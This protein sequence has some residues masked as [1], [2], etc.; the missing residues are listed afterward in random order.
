MKVFS[1]NNTDVASVADQIAA[2]LPAQPT[3]LLYF[4]S[5][6]FSPIDIAEVLKKLYPQVPTMGCSTAGEIMTGHM[7][8]GHL[9]IAGFSNEQVAEAKVK[10]IGQEGVKATYRELTGGAGDPDLATHVGIILMDGLASQEEVI[11]DALGSESDITF[12]GGSAGDE[13]K[14]VQTHV[15]A[16]SELV[17]HGG[18]L[19]LLHVPGGFDIIKTQ[20][21]SSTG[22]CLL[23]TKVDRA[24]RAVLEFDGKPA[25]LA[26]AEALGVPADSELLNSFMAHPLGLMAGD[27]PFVRAPLRTDNDKLHFSCE[28]HEGLELSLL[29]ATDIVADTSKSL[30]QFDFQALVVFNC[31]L[32]T[33]E[34]KAKGKA[35]DFGELFVKPTIG[36]STYGEAYIGHIN[37]TATILAFR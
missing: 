23:P 37:Q 28:V 29:Q 17:K 12:V 5:I 8:E 9:V 16:N 14:F 24:S 1:T 13:L 21:F 10:A 20:S 30:A 3:F 4:H 31:I 33:L 6:A 15:A 32:R 35:K 18:A 19:A 27:E 25:T 7:L 2:A 36:F 26:Y 22:K 34:L 11:M